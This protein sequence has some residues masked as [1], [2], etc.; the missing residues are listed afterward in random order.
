MRYSRKLQNGLRKPAFRFWLRTCFAHQRVVL[1]PSC[2]I[3]CLCRF[4]LP[5]PCWRSAASL[6]RYPNLRCCSRPGSLQLQLILW[7]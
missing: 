4:G 5:C 1:G 2:N 7:G 6:T 3:G